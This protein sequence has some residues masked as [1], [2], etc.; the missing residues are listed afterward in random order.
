MK[1]L[2]DECLP[3]KLKKELTEFE[4]KTVPEMGWAGK[5]NGELLSLAE[6]EFDIFITSDQNL[7]YQQNLKGKNIAIIILVA[8]NNRIETLVPLIPKAKIEM[9]TINN[10]EIV[11]VSE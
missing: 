10:G 8:I 6:N 3:K 11:L 7:Q 1:V 4:V 5:K 2:L 9:Q